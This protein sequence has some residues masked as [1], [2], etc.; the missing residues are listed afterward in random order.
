MCPPQELGAGHDFLIGQGLGV[1]QPRVVVEGGV[2]EQIPAPTIALL[3]GSSGRAPEGT[4]AAAVGG[5][6]PSFFISTWT[7]SPGRARS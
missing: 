5:T 7:S 3:V 2:Q 1:G 4:M 6:R